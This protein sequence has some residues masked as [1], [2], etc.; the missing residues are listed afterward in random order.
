MEYHELVREVKE[1]GGDF[2]KIMI[3]GIMVYEQY[4][5]MSEEPLGNEEIRELIHIAHEEGMAVMVHANGADTVRAAVLAGADSIEH[6]NY[7]DTDVLDAMKAGKTVWVP[8]IVTTGNLFG[9]GRYPQEELQKIFDRASR[10]LQY[11]WENRI[12]MALGSDAGAYRVLHGQG[13]QDE[14][15]IFCRILGETVQLREHLAEGES[16]IRRKFQEGKR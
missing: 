7:I 14:Y 16:I 5:K 12:L 1:R 3:S 15:Q 10:N 8:T 9:C 6:G 4:G 11:A 13:I 2:I